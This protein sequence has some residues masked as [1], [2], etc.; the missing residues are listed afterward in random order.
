MSRLPHRRQVSSRRNLLLD[1]YFT[2]IVVA[3]FSFVLESQLCARLARG[4]CIKKKCMRRLP[5]QVDSATTCRPAFAAICEIS[6]GVQ[7]AGRNLICR[8]QRRVEETESP[9]MSHGNA[10]A[11]A[12]NR[13]HDLRIARASHA[14]DGEATN[15]IFI[16]VNHNTRR[17]IRCLNSP[18]VVPSRLRATSPLAVYCAGRYAGGP[19]I[20]PY[21]SLTGTR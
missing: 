11:R 16:H 14:R 8:R 20:A 18:R 6:R 1:T 4:V 21:L 5:L 7:R 17:S 13:T 9:A 19:F 3:F 2:E 12:H 15:Q 10:C